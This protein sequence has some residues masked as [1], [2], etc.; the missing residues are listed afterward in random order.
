MKTLQS[1]LS[2]ELGGYGVDIFF[3]L[4]SSKGKV[5]MLLD[6]GN[7]NKLLL[8]PHAQQQLGIELDKSKEKTAKNISLDLIGY[9]I[10]EAEARE[11]EM[12]YDGMLNYDTI[13]KMLIT[14]DLRTGKS[15][16]RANS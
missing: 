11:R 8:A 14:M 6:T 12:I 16:A 2:R 7:T 10:F 3:A 9:G 15:W 5:W 1:R 4:K 13:A